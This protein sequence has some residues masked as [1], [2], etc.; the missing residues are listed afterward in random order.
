MFL[1]IWAT[2]HHNAPPASIHIYVSWHLTYQSYFWIQ[3]EGVFHSCNTTCPRKVLSG[4]P[5]QP[6][7]S[8]NMLLKPRNLILFVQIYR[9]TDFQPRWCDDPPSLKIHC[10]IV[11]SCDWQGN[12]TRISKEL[13][14][15]FQATLHRLSNCRKDGTGLIRG[16]WGPRCHTYPGGLYPYRQIRHKN[17]WINFSILK[18]SRNLSNTYRMPMKRDTAKIEKPASSSNGTEIP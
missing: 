12:C 8:R 16:R 10:S 17:D 2:S 3:V 14:G 15:T 7:R 5:L 6:S 1:N 18:I 11:R 4:R 9:Q 13:S